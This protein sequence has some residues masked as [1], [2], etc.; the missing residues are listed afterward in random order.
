LDTTLKGVA[1]KLRR[2]IQEH[3]SDLKEEMKWNVPTYSQNQNVCSIMVHKNHV[4]FQ[5]FNGAHIEDSQDLA[6]TGK[7]M[8]HLKLSS[9]DDLNSAKLRQYLKQALELDR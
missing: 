7:D 4:N 1:C 2:V 5:I 6:G 8:R 3:F 9:L